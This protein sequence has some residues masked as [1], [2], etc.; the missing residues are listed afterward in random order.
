M[1]TYYLSRPSHDLI[2]GTIHLGSSKSI[3]NRAL[4]IRALCNDDFHIGRLAA[5]ADTQ[6][7]EYLLTTKSEIL[8][9]GAAGTTFRFMT[10]YLA[11][12]EGT[13]VLTGSARM[14]QRPIGILVKALN[15]LGADIHYLNNEGY[16]PLKINSPRSIGNV[17]QVEIGANVSSQFISALLMIAPV[18]PKG[19]T[20]KLNGQIVS[21]SYIQMTL[22]LMQWF[23]VQY[24]WK[25]NLIR[26]PKQPYQPRSF[27]VEADWSAAS[28]YYAI[29]ALAK[30]ADIYLNGLF[31]ESIQGDA[32][33]P[34]LMRELGVDT[35]FT[36]SGIRLRKTQYYNKQLT[37][38]FLNCP[39]I[40]QTIAVIA[41]GL[42][43]N[44]TLH[45]LDTLY[46]KETNRVVALQRELR[47]VSVGFKAKKTADHAHQITG[48]VRMPSETPVFD[49][50]EDHRMAMAFSPLALLLGT[51]GINDP[52]VVRKSY[53]AFWKD[54]QKLG[55]VIKEG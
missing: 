7:L 30:E 46:I 24:Q 16:P 27:I 53:P 23:G 36:K 54:L 26:I 25:D 9:T 4:I 13:Q 40:A 45:D 51:V 47:K 39:D 52:Q 50:Y 44:A 42:G 14:Q 6:T 33:L 18:L 19:L 17:N 37:H 55:F 32:V 12:Q 1:T 2:Q 48:Y 5:A 22:A 10:A 15:Y 8:D 28:Y 11:L 38:S 34:S 49:T 35:T 21:K 31:Q 41:G 43:I 29:A 20:L 3:S